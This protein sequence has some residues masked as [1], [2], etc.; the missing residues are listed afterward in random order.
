MLKW[1]FRRAAAMAAAGMMLL[2]ACGGNNDTSA[3]SAGGDPVRGGHLTYLDYQPLKSFQLSD[4]NWYQAQP[5][6]NNVFDRLVFRGPDGT[7]TEPWIAESWTLSEDGRTY[8]FVIRDGVTYSDGTPLDAENV[9]ENFE[10]RAFGD[11][12]GNVKHTAWPDVENVTADNAGR[13]VAIT[14]KKPYPYFLTTLT[15]ASAS[16]LA[17]SSYFDLDA[18]GQN[19]A[20]SLVGSGP[21][22]IESGTLDEVKLKRREGY[23]WAPNGVANQGE[24]YLDSFSTVGVTEDSVR[25]GSLSSGQGDLIHYI[26]PTSQDVAEAQ[27]LKVIT[28]S[29][30]DQGTYLLVQRSTAP[31]LDDPRV[32]QAITYA[33]DKQK[34]IDTVYAPN[35]KAATGI[36]GSAGQD[37]VDQSDQIGYNPDKA[38]QLLD[39]AGWKTGPNGIRTKNGKPLKV[40]ALI[41]VYN[42]GASSTFEYLQQ[43][44]KQAGIELELRQA[45]WADYPNAAKSPDIGL[46]YQSVNHEA[47]WSLANAIRADGADVFKLEGSDAELE[48]LAQNVLYGTPKSEEER[49]QA[50]VALSQYVVDKAY[51]L[52]LTERTQTFVS[53][54]QVHGFSQTQAHPWLYLTWKN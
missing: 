3:D 46:I 21:F 38:A 39:E 29:Y 10:F 30:G 15:D 22:V 2:A 9:K 54:S 50:A 35:Y 43:Q 20:T 6:A 53:N 41:D 8:T 19:R 31:N 11:D 42:V 4:L 23:S 25:L 32:R 52:P 17:A 16:G 27:G 48:K 34:L 14:L 13:T 18:E 36:F 49:H 7:G 1:R 40:V 45:D 28:Q 37:Y 51:V 24:A 12:K 47:A 44:L 5:I 26:D 33:V